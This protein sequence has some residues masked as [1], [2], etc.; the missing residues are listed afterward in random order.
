M[1]RDRD[2][3][4]IANALPFLEELDISYPNKFS[5]MELTD[6]THVSSIEVTDTG[7]EAL[8]S[9]LKNLLKLD[10]SGNHFV[11][12]KSIV[13]LSSNCLKL[14]EVNVIDCSCI[15]EMGIH[16]MLQNSPDISVMSICGIR[17]PLVSSLG[18]EPLK[19]GRALCS[20]D[21]CVSSF[22]DE[23]LYVIAKAGL[24]LKRFTLSCCL[25]FTACGVAS[26]LFAYQSLEYLAL[27]DVRFLTDQLMT[28]WS[29]YLGNLA[30]IKLNLCSLLTSLTVFTLIK[31]CP[32]L[33][34]IDMEATNVGRDVCLNEFVK[35]PQVK[36]LNLARNLYMSDERLMQ[37]ASTTPNLEFLDVCA[38]PGITGRSIA[39]ISESCLNIKHLRINDCVRIKELGSNIR[40]HKLE[41]LDAT[42]SRLGDE[43]LV[44]I[45]KT[46][47]GLLKLQL[48]GSERVGTKGV[49]VVVENCTR[50]R[51]LNLKHCHNVTP[52]TCNWMVFNRP[53]L[54][55]IIPPSF[56][57][58]TESQRRFLNS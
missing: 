35:N 43:G 44:N 9:N 32:L 34:D 3:V 7:I 1:L 8:W 49:E 11:T 36:S 4:T 23:Y 58:T 18:G 17:V 37:I 40:L 55:K 13:A 26:V 39:E 28:E 41:V 12:D 42:R 51:E 38:S 45:G 50:L 16:F 31:N 30:A 25:D 21:F 14:K 48:E 57:V 2:L 56:Q 53:S 54:K 46:C 33:Q 15:T 52:L 20:L 6:P 10:I 19:F 5:S 29:Q 22:P 24:P 27:V 47:L